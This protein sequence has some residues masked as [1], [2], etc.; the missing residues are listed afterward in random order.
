MLGALALTAD[1]RVSNVP[2]GDDVIAVDLMR[3]ENICAAD[4]VSPT[5]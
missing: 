4:L 5:C 3:Q 1:E 2:V